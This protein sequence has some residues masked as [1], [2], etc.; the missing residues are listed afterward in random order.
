MAQIAKAS[1]M[2]SGSWSLPGIN[3]HI[4]IICSRTSRATSR[5]RRMNTAPVSIQDFVTP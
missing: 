5:P 2:V 3:T 1:C 4:Q